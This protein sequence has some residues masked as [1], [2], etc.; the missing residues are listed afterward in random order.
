MS[1]QFSI[2]SRSHFRSAKANC[3]TDSAR[4]TATARVQ[5]QRSCYVLRSIVSQG[6]SNPTLS[7]I[8]MVS[9]SRTSGAM[10][11]SIAATSLDRPVFAGCIQ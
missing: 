1:D 4:E 7:R 2:R 8:H 5:V 11:V 6:Y 10:V 9:C 3:I